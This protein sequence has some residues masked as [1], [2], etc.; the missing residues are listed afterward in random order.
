[1]FPK[2]T[3]RL[4]YEFTMYYI[5]HVMLLIP[6]CTA[7]SVCRVQVRQN[8]SVF[9]FLL[10]H[11]LSKTLIPHLQRLSSGQLNYTVTVSRRKWQY[12]PNENICRGWI[13]EKVKDFIFWWHC[14]KIKDISLWWLLSMRQMITF[15]SRLFIKLEAVN[16]QLSVSLYLYYR[17]LFGSVWTGI[18]QPFLCQCSNSFHLP[19]LFEG[20]LL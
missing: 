12:L 4:M 14:W 19:C 3:F 16:N 13:R 20:L 7:Y 18:C 17:C 10:F 9:A 8:V 15:L 5:V 2:R 1:M 6:F 11:S